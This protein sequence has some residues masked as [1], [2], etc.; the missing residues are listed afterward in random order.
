VKLLAVLGLLVA[1]GVLVGG[2]GAAVRAGF[3]CSPSCGVS[4]G[5]TVTFTSTST[6]SSAIRIYEWDLDGDGLHG[7]A[8]DPDEPYGSNAGSVQRTFSVVGS[9][10]VG[11]RVT[12]RDGERSTAWRSVTV[13][14]PPPPAVPGVAPLVPS[15][16][17]EDEDGDGVSNAR[18]LCPATASRLRS[19]LAGC[20]LVDAVVSP[21]ALLDSA[22]DSVARTRTDQGTRRQ[23]RRLSLGLGLLRRA[24]ARLAADPCAGSR[25][26]GKGLGYARTAL[27]GISAAARRRQRSTVALIGRLHRRHPDAGGDTDALG[28]LFTTLAMKR[29]QAK[30]TVADLARLRDLFAA[31]CRSRVGSRK[32][33]VRSRVVEIDPT[34]SLAMLSDGSSLA[35]GAARG[36]SGLA[37]GVRV[38]A[39]GTQLEG[40]ILIADSIS[41]QGLDFEPPGACSNRRSRRFRISPSRTPTS[42]TTTTAATSTATSTCWRGA[43]GSAP[44]SSGT[45]TSTTTTGSSC[46]STTET[47][48]DTRWSGSRSDR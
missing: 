36:L 12:N 27:A 18:D 45:A 16:P 11:L 25:T 1:S 43:W 35:L 7:V 26:A 39:K 5:T 30:E 29:A 46:S 22:A 32:R 37:P 4:R 8:D 44:S 31:A 14:P 10:R 40:R 24:G 17:T 13:A 48:R 33:T 15:L 9:F 6:S 21:A 42:C 28:T 41:V 3:D 38:E 19:R 20:A 23:L 47:S 2:T 34:Q